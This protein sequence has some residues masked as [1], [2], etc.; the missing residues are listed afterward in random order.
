MD[1]G[2]HIIKTA[3]VLDLSRPNFISKKINRK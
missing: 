2:A 1:F 3:G